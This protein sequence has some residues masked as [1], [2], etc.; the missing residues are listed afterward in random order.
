MKEKFMR[1]MYGRHGVDQYSIWIFVL[2]TIL[3]FIGI[4][5]GNQILVMLALIPLGYT[6]FRILSKNYVKRYNEN[7]KFMSA[8][9]PIRNKVNYMKKKW[10]D[11][12]DYKYFKCPQCK[13]NVRVPKGHGNITITCPQCGT[14]FDK[15]S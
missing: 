1:F 4:F 12:K 2:Y 11:R 7:V 8:T 9:Q 6:Y 13:K 15:K 3:T 14:K 5:S 10:K